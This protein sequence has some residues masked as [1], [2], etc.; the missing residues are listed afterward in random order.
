MYLPTVMALQD[1]TTMQALLC[2]TQYFFR[3]PVREAPPC[4][5][6]YYSSDVRREQ[7]ETPIW[8]V[9]SFLSIFS[10]ELLMNEL[11]I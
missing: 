11:G 9:A 10:I 3:A 4:Y 6:Y 2:L 1:I 8:F 5:R 7:T